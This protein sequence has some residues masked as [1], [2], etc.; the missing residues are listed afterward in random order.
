VKERLDG[1]GLLLK[2]RIAGPEG[3]RPAAPLVS[4][5]DGR[6]AG[7][8]AND[9][10]QQH[11]QIDGPVCRLHAHGWCHPFTLADERERVALDAG[12]THA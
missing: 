9:P 4:G 12:G 8:L 6:E 11:F 10:T 2:L 1:P 5:H 3:E 7:L